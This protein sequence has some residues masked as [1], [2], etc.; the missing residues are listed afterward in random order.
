MNTT[1]MASRR[2]EE[3]GAQK[4]A[5]QGLIAPQEVQVLQDSQEPLQGD[6]FPIGG[7]GDEVP[8]VPSDI[9][10]GEIREALLAFAQA[11]TTHL[12]RDGWPRVNAL[13]S[14]MTSKFIDF[15]RMNSPIFLCSKIR[16]NP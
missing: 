12:I 15:V 9:T 2:L 8:V 7:E 16:E 4:E 11:M 1:R 6:K 10:D 3:G 13:E 5:P 14:T